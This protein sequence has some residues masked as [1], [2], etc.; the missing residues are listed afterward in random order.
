MGINLELDIK[1]RY[2]TYL[3]EALRQIP[4]VSDVSYWG[5]EHNEQFLNIAFRI[6]DPQ[7]LMVIA[8]AI[9]N[10]YGGPPC[11]RQSQNWFIYVDCSDTF[12][13]YSYGLRSFCKTE[14]AYVW[15]SN[16]AINIRDTLSKANVLESYQVG[17]KESSLSE[18]ERLR[19]L[20]QIEAEAEVKRVQKLLK[21][22]KTDNPLDGFELDIV[23]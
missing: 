14:Y 18:D 4:S 2:M 7:S 12:P 20:Y 16:I 6:S 15:A 17:L 9:D 13:G 10:R 11:N 23:N 1:Y 5:G 3:C 21:N 8:R 22:R 19:R